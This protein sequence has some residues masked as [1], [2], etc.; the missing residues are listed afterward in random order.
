MRSRR[1]KPQVEKKKCR[2]LSLHVFIHPT[3]LQWDDFFCKE[4]TLVWGCWHCRLLSADLSALVSDLDSNVYG[5]P[6]KGFL[7]SSF[8]VSGPAQPCRPK[9]L[10]DVWNSPRNPAIWILKVL[11]KCLETDLLIYCKYLLTSRVERF[12]K[13]GA[14]R[15]GW[16]TQYN[17][18]KVQFWF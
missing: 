14:N 16:S 7:P 18:E 2:H 12:N 6:Q 15:I 5:A 9:I 8:Q 3:I 11:I 1:K 10:E 4:I 13:I 17:S